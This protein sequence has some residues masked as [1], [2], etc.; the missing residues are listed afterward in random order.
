[1]N[2]LH[3]AFSSEDF[4]KL[5]EG[6]HFDTFCDKLHD[7]DK[8]FIPFIE[9]ASDYAF[10]EYHCVG[11]YDMVLY[12]QE[13]IDSCNISHADFLKLLVIG[14]YIPSV[15]YTNLFDDYGFKDSTT[16]DYI[17]RLSR[18]YL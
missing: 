17:M 8:A 5:T 10:E 15:L 12:L 3:N 6:M 2:Y 9:K 4:E 18:V 13:F 11:Y 7:N 16:F 1:M 14:K